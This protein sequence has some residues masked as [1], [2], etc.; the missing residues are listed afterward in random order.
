MGMRCKYDGCKIAGCEKPH[1]YKGFCSKHRYQFRAGIIDENGTQLREFRR[2]PGGKPC[3]IEGCVNKSES[4][5]FCEK[6]RAHYRRGI[7]DENG[8]RIRELKAIYGQ[9]GCKVDGCKSEH[10]AKGF[11]DKH[12]RQV[13]AGIIDKDGKQLRKLIRHHRAGMMDGWDSQMERGTH[14]VME[15]YFG[16]GSTCE[17]QECHGEFEFYQIDG[18]HPDPSK[19]TIEPRKALYY[20]LPDEPEIVAELDTLMWVCSHCHIVLRF[21]SDDI[22]YVETNKGKK[23]ARAMD[24]ASDALKERFGTK[25]LDCGRELGRRTMVFHHR[26]PSEKVCSISDLIGSYRLSFVLEEAEKCD[27]LCSPCHRKRHM[28]EDGGSANVNIDWDRRNAL[29]E[30]SPIGKKPKRA[31][32]CIV[33][34]CV[35]KHMGLGFCKNHLHHYHVGNIDVQGNALREYSTNVAVCTA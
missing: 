13:L 25:C 5:G 27:L 4:R 19:K 30:A 1:A 18:H 16:G 11:C 24:R 12:Y 2:V 10:T 35:E 9:V 26:N 31:P 21:N 32:V 33:E 17:C 15:R 28:V 34:R 22:P 6:H 7:I 8:N 20:Y 3:K 23:S 29:I 14:F